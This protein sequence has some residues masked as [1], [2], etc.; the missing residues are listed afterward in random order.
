L[1]FHK[2]STILY[3]YSVI[4]YLYSVILYLYLLTF[5]ISNHILMFKIL[6]LLFVV[7]CFAQL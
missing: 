6:L 5:R 3:L 4:L 2:Y 7:G 1:I